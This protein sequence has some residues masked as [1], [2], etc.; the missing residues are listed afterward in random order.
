MS[1]I[2]CPKTVIKFEWE[3]KLN[4]TIRYMEYVNV[5][6]YIFLPDWYIKKIK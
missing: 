2:D 1:D 4:H 6:Q 5:P 3:P